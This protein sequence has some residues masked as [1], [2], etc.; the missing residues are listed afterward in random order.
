LNE[1]EATRE[2]ELFSVNAEEYAAIYARKSSKDNRDG[3]KSQIM[4]CEEKL[5]EENLHLYK[6]YTDLISATRYEPMNRSGF[7][8]LVYDM[9]D[10]KFKTI[11]VFKRDRLA[12][13]P[14]HMKEI[15]TL[16]RNYNVRI[17]YSCEGE[18]QPTDSPMSDFVENII[19]A[20]AQIEPKMT[21]LRAQ[22][23]IDGKRQRGEYEAS[24]APSGLKKAVWAEL[25][26]DEEK[27]LKKGV[28]K[29]YVKDNLK[30]GYIE[31]LFEK[32][33][34]MEYT[35]ENLYSLSNELNCNS[36]S[37]EFSVKK[38]KSIIKNIVYSGYMTISAN[39][40]EEDSLYYNEKNGELE[41]REGYFQKCCNVI[42]IV[43]R[44]IW[45]KCFIKLHK[46]LETRFVSEKMSFIFNG[47]M[48]CKCKRRVHYVDGK[49]CCPMDC[50]KISEEIIV[51]FLLERIINDV[52]NETSIKS[53]MKSQI[54]KLEARLQAFNESLKLKN[55]CLDK[56][57][58]DMIK[59]SKIESDKFAKKL[60][61]VNEIV[62]HVVVLKEETVFYKY[63][64]ENFFNF[65][66]KQ[67][68][69][70][71]IKNMMLNPNTTQ[72]FLKIII[73]KV[74]VNGTEQ[75]F[76][77]EIQYGSSSSNCIYKSI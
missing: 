31:Q 51:P 62:S 34:E 21:G 57:V 12:R 67:N 71:I 30:S 73:E 76:T 3:I 11:I 16:C 75:E 8:E 37:N 5:E 56:E 45:N 9:Q 58:M 59:K 74:V 38:I 63:L 39:N 36:K 40:K 68:K 60:K 44:E 49:Y 25:K 43:S 2:I 33:C 13:D 48:F 7:R 65:F 23:G 54:G 24:R 22:A 20:V 46:N 10:N 19:M 61:E 64:E 14:M 50:F 77:A 66:S 69:S 53:Y 26:E 32:F 27:Y 28:K 15:K 55:I 1:T 70:P 18:F 47:I 6:S 17:V 41:I 72:D 4:S 35:S 42:G 29:Y 52:I